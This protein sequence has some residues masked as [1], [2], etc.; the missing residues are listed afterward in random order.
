MRGLVMA[1]SMPKLLGDLGDHAIGSGPGS[2]RSMSRIV[3][4]L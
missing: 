1:S 3:L 4:S 2:P